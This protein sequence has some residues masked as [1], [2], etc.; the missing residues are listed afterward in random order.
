MKVECQ[1]VINSK[2]ICPS[3][4]K[5]YRYKGYYLDSQR[6]PCCNHVIIFKDL[7]IITYTMSILSGIIAASIFAFVI[8]LQMS[9]ILY[10]L[11]CIIPIIIAVECLQRILVPILYNKFYAKNDDQHETEIIEK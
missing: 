8:S 1:R 4:K 5:K 3:C 2:I 9:V 7:K 10:F 6:C 11:L